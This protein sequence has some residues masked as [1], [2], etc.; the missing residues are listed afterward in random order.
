MPSQNPGDK[1]TS[2]IK[3]VPSKA[4]DTLTLGP[5]RRE[6]SKYVS[7]KVNAVESAA[8]NQFS[9]AKELLSKDPEPTKS[10]PTGSS[11]A[12]PNS[13][14]HGG[15]VKKTGIA[16][17]HKGETVIPAEKHMSN[18][19]EETF[20]LSEHRAVMHIRKGGLH[21]ALHVPEGETIPKERIEEA[22]HSKNPHLRK[23]AVLAQTFASFH[24]G[25]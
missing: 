19:K 21:R 18:N 4:L 20:H 2:D 16:L 15:V 12:T 3:K 9:Q 10:A 14:K 22:T 1:L 6:L 8:K 7:N 11:A 13:Y 17:V 23:M 25:K 24:H 5:Q